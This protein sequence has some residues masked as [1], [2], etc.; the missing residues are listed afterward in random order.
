[1]TVARPAGVRFLGS[2]MLKKF[3]H[4]CIVSSALV[5]AARV[6]A[7]AQD[8]TLLGG[9]LSTT[10]TGHNGLQVAAPNVT[11][12]ERYARQISGFE[13]FHRRNGK[14]EGLGPRFVNASC[15]GCHVQNGKGPLRFGGS[16]HRGSTMVVKVS[17]PGLNGD[18]S[19]R[20]VPSIGE[21]LKDH[22]LSG[23]RHHNIR[24]SWNIKRGKYADGTPYELRSPRLRF[25]VAGQNP[26]RLRVSLRMSPLLFGLGLLE[27]IPESTVLAMSDPD[28]S[29][30]DGISGKPQYVI[31]VES[32][33]FALG[34]FGFRASN[35]TVEQQSAGA[36]VNDMGLTNSYFPG[37]DGSKDL[38]DD[39]LDRLVIYQLIA[40]VPMA[41]NQDDPQVQLGKALFQQ[42]KCDG[43]HRMTLTTGPHEAP[44]LENQ[45][46]HPFTDLLLHDMGPGLADKRREFSASGREWRTTP[47]WGLGFSRT[48]SRVKQTYLH[49]G[50]ARTISE[51]ILWHGGEGQ[52]SR[53]AFKKLN[54]SQRRA[55]IRFLNSL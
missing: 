55:L 20:S 25:R 21:Q 16:G 38:S 9:D 52:A 27:A 14:A 43:C 13:I 32:G 31:D 39:E 54:K 40:G 49:D 48:V 11:D 41:R 5:L 42:I 15:G 37:N 19:P 51:A 45:E 28:D 2:P 18:G 29:D 44:E 17:V 12:P 4:C 34:R 22:S 35:P 6:P 50:R 8:L 47:L 36:A 10:L 7:A 24:L 3:L 30:G 1:M 26:R 33:E 46:I 53:D 23:L